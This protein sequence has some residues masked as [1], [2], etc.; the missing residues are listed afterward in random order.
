MS[1]AE[2]EKEVPDTIVIHEKRLKISKRVLSELKEEENEDK[3][4]RKV[5]YRFHEGLNNKRKQV[6][7]LISS[8]KYQQKPLKSILDPHCNQF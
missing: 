1:K 4:N 5:F 3:I 2:I 6:S 8:K 7:R